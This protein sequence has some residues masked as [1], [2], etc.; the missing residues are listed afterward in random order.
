MLKKEA[1]QRLSRWYCMADQNQRDFWIHTSINFDKF[2]NTAFWNAAPN[3]EFGT[4][5]WRF[6]DS[7]LHQTCCHWF[8]VQVLCS[9]AYLNLF[10]QLPF[11]K[12]AS[13][14]HFTGVISGQALVNSRWISIFFKDMTLYANLLF[15]PTIVQFSYIFKNTLHTMLRCAKFLCSVEITLLVQ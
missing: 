10:S 5:C 8:L 7:P 11:P 1:S 4:Y 9:L 15:C 13:W 14:H 3:H 6:K 12:K 2:P